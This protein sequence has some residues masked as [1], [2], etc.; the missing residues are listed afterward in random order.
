MNNEDVEQRKGGTYERSKPSGER[1]A[2]TICS[3]LDDIP[4]WTTADTESRA[5][6]RRERKLRMAKESLGNETG[7]KRR[8]RSTEVSRTLEK[9]FY[10]A[11]NCMKIFV[12]YRNARR[13]Y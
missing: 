9:A 2:F 6:E 3:S 5:S 8:R 7:K 11:A 4:A 12:S 13:V 10:R 1:L